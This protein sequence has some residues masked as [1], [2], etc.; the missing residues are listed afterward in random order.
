MVVIVTGTNGP[1][2]PN[3]PP[4]PYYYAIE[5]QDPSKV[6]GGNSLTYVMQDGQLVASVLG[7][8]LENGKWVESEPFSTNVS[9]EAFGEG[10]TRIAFETWVEGPQMDPETTVY[11]AFEVP[12]NFAEP[13]PLDRLSLDH[14][15]VSFT[16]LNV[17]GSS[18]V[19]SVK[20]VQ[21]P[22]PVSVG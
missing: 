19:L 20:R 8:V 17:G 9:Q 16:Q 13:L 4:V 10:G 2:M 7:I 15:L 21:A 5:L 18:P 1:Q 22:P 11:L 14:C 3:Q 6:V 12:V